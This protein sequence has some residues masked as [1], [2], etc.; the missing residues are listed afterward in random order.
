[1]KSGSVAQ[2]PSLRVNDE[3]GEF[4]AKVRAMNFTGSQPCFHPFDHIKPTSLVAA[5]GLLAP[6]LMPM[7]GAGNVRVASAIITRISL[8]RGL[9]GFVS[10]YVINLA[11]NKI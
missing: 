6:V 7:L 8:I 2:A 10:T 3:N 1:M 11:G 5:T 4:S 9:A